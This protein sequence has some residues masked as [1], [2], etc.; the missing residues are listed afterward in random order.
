MDLTVGGFMRDSAS[1]D[2]DDGHYHYL[3]HPTCPTV[4]GQHSEK[5]SSVQRKGEK[6]QEAT[7]M[8]F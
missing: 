4:T 6:D 1:Y 8:I 5:L 3:D 7:R 2:L